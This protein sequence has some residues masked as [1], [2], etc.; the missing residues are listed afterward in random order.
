M[1]SDV[2]PSGLIYAKFILLLRTTCQDLSQHI[3]TPAAVY[4]KK[5]QTMLYSP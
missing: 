4:A 3:Q 5:N 1:C 2:K